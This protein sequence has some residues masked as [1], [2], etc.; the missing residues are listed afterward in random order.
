MH[1]LGGRRRWQ[2]SS[3]TVGRYT[4]LHLQVGRQAATRALITLGWAGIPAFPKGVA[5]RANP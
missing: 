2:A 5:V 4:P 1:R 3:Y